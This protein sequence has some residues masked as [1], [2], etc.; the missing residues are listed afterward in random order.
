MTT[1]VTPNPALKS[2][3]TPHYSML[4]L[5]MLGS[6]PAIER[7]RLFCSGGSKVDQ[8][9]ESK[10]PPSSPVVGHYDFGCYRQNRLLAAQPS[11]FPGF[12]LKCHVTRGW[13]TAVHNIA[14]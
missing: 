3:G 8:C 11:W 7:R 5:A 9:K 13:S 4:G 6:H 2:T 1:R 14:I 12:R 10:I